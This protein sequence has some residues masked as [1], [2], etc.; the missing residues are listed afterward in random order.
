MIEVEEEGF[1]VIVVVIVIVCSRFSSCRCR[2]Y[3]VVVGW[4]CMFVM[5]IQVYYETITE[6]STLSK[7]VVRVR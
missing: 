5:F 2:L 7:S 3:Y 4:L 6:I 1:I